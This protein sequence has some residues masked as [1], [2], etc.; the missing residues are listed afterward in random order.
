MVENPLQMPTC[1]LG[2]LESNL[3]ETLCVI[4]FLDNWYI[5][6]CKVV[7]QQFIRSVWSP[8]LDIKMMTS[9]FQSWNFTLSRH[10]KLQQFA[11]AVSS[12]FYNM[13]TST[14]F[15]RNFPLFHTFQ[16]LIAFIF[17]YWHYSCDTYVYFILGL[18]V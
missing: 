4:I 6:D 8:F 11:T 14:I 12:S 1:T 16:C 10:E 9:F 7:G 17:C 18:H 15:P 2:W 5:T 13:H 3:S